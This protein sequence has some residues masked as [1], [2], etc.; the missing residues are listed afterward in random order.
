MGVASGRFLPTDGF[1]SVIGAMTPVTRGDGS[2]DPDIRWLRGLGATTA[3]GVRIVCQQ[4]TVFEIPAPGSPIWE[5]HCDGVVSPP[6]DDLFPGR[7][8]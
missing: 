2:R 6:Y 4:V 3:A 8:D 7:T 5:V 1:A